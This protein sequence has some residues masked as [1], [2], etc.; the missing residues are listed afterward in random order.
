MS[1][2]HPNTGA[3]LHWAE[4]ARGTRFSLKALGILLSSGFST[5]RGKA[6]AKLSLSLGGELEILLLVQWRF[7]GVIFKEGIIS[8]YYAFQCIY[9][10]IHTYVCIFGTPWTVVPQAP[11]PMGFPR[12][13][14]WSELPCPPGNL[15]NLGS[16]LHLLHGQVDSLPLHHLGKPY[17]CVCLYIYLSMCVCVYLYIYTHICVCV[18]V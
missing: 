2:C 1:P 14:Y 17:M 11:P 6:T 13:E 7:W 16:N 8:I 18:C 5:G 3:K 12:Q 10:C 9:T 4:L 15:P